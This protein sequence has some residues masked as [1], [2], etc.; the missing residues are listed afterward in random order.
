MIIGGGIVLDL[1]FSVICLFFNIVKFWVLFMLV[2][3]G[4]IKYENIVLSGFDKWDVNDLLVF[5]KG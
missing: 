5:S 4:G 3:L 2:I 1:Y